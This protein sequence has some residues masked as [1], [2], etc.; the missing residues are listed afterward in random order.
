M[1]CLR[2]VSADCLT[3]GESH[4]DSG[5]FVLREQEYC[6]ALLSTQR[7]PLWGI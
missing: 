2:M 7:V 1:S 4:V 3:Q 6:E 5:R